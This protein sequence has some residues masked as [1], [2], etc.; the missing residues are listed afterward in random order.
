MT[1]GGTK[2]PEAPPEDEP[3]G[4]AVER[5]VTLVVKGGPWALVVV[6][7][8]TWLAGDYGFLNS[9]SKAA[10]RGIREH[11]EQTKQQQHSL[12]KIVNVLEE[13]RR[14]QAQSG[15]IAC[16]KEAK[17]DSD[18]NECIRKFPIK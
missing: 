1:T 13:Q 7:V 17:V 15:L 11:V 4:G 12:D 14:I 9:E 16:F 2:R 3:M 18:R 8:L 5:L 10:A 6:I